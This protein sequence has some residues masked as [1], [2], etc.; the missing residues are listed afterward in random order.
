MLI[1][2]HLHTTNSDGLE[3]LENLTSRLSQSI[4]NQK[5]ILGVV[6]HHHLT[7][8]KIVHYKN[9]ELIPGMEISV[10]VNKEAYHLVAYS[11]KPQITPKMRNQLDAIIN[12]YNERAKKILRQLK[13]AGY[14]L[15]DPIRN[16]KLPSPIY[17]YDIA[18]QLG[19]LIKIK[20]EK[21]TI[22]WAK[23]NDNLLFVKEENFLPEISEAAS[24]LHES[25]FKV[26]WAHPGSKNFSK[27]NLKTIL[28]NIDGIEVFC[29]KNDL[30]KTAFFLDLANKQNLLVSGGSDYHGKGRGVSEPMFCLP[31]TLY[32]KNMFLCRIG[33]KITYS[34]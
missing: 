31:E 21:E 32:D 23:E 27:S 26:F 15:P 25:N 19:T 34:P 17:T 16:P 18:R 33:G 6:D 20:T 3:S 11:G 2:L 5:L 29:P 14:K 28:N 30:N 4:N 9:I 10:N 8:K 1:D 13:N 7:I 22:K 24:L 12:G